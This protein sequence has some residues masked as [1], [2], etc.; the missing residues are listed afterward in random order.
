MRTGVFEALADPVRRRLLE[1]VAERE[2]TAGE[3]AGEFET[4]RPA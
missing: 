4:S 3:L 2:R 1:L